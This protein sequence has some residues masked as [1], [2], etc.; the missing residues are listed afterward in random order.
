[1]EARKEVI[2]SEIQTL[3]LYDT[4]LYYAV[5]LMQAAEQN[6]NNEVR[7]SRNTVLNAWEWKKSVDIAK[8]GRL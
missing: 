7:I 4:L 6:R 8:H 3:M 5:L 2:E 1:M